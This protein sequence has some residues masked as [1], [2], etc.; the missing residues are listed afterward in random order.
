MPQQ[1]FKKRDLSPPKRLPLPKVLAAQ[2]AKP[3]VSNSPATVKDS[4]KQAMIERFQELEALR[5][6]WDRNKAASAAKVRQIFYFS[7]LKTGYSGSINK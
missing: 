7:S 5:H 4:V 3:E 2:E 6:R 1:F